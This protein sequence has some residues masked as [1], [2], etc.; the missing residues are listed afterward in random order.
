VLGNT[1]SEAT[2][3]P[4]GSS[5]EGLQLSGAVDDAGAQLGPFGSHPGGEGLSCGG[6]SAWYAGLRPLFERVRADEQRW[7]GAYLSLAREYAASLSDP[8]A[9]K[10]I[11]NTARMTVISN[12]HLWASTLGVAANYVTMGGCGG[13]GGGEVAAPPGE[14]A[15]PGC[16]VPDWLQFSI[17]SGAVEFGQDCQHR[18]VE[19]HT[20]GPL[21]PFFRISQN[22]TKDTT[23][24]M[25]GGKASINALKGTPIGKW[26]KVG[27]SWKI[28]AYATFTKAN[29]LDPSNR[30]VDYGWITPG[31]PSASASA[32][33]VKISAPVDRVVGAFGWTPPPAQFQ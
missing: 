15:D 9:R 24:F 3:Y 25:Y 5:A 33:G 23:T 2:H 13:G 28:G 4:L 30:M 11:L 16:L 26:V 21:G 10:F 8:K 29:P 32:F 1:S 6:V 14:T 17:D 27:E 12:Q 7:S 31:H 20:P 18:Y 22:L 19:F